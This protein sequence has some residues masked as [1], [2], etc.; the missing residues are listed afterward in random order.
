MLAKLIVFQNLTFLPRDCFKEQV[1]NII[2]KRKNI[3]N[4]L[5]KNFK[6]RKYVGIN[7]SKYKEY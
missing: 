4:Y 1:D 5:M 7:V 6:V 2:S 3:S